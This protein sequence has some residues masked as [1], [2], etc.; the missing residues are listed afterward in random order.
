METQQEPLNLPI[1]RFTKLYWL[2]KILVT[3]ELTFTDPENWDD[4]NDKC[5]IQR[6]KYLNNFK[7]LLALCFTTKREVYHFWKISGG[8]DGVRIQ[9]DKKKLD[10]KLKGHNIPPLKLAEYKCLDELIR[11]SESDPDIIRKLPFLKGNR[12]MKMSM[13]GV[14]YTNQRKISKQKK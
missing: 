10:K 3:K 11:A 4:E 1:Y 12:Y 7:T 8:A 9:F 2:L 6:Y 5:S 13:N 14:L